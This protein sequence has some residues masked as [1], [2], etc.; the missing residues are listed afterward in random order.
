MKDELRECTVMSFYDPK[1]PTTVVVDG[2]P[3]GLGAVLTQ[4]NKPI[5]YASRSLRA[6]EQRY[7]QIERE[8]LAIVFGCEHFH[9]YLIGCKFRIDTDHKPLL[10]I[11]N[12]L[13]PPLRIERWG[14]RLLPYKLNMRKVLTT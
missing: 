7:S 3:F 13:N 2:S 12:K 1:K 10:T 11:W 14:L 8:A 5:A 9:M 6:V 4:D